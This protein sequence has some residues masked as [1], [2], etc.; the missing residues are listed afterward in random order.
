M[1]FRP[2][3]R[4]LR[5]IGFYTGRVLFGT[6]VC[7]A[8]PASVAALLGERNELYAFV[9]AA[10]LA[11]AVGRLAELALH[12]RGAPTASHG[13]AVVAL[14]WITVP[15]FA[16]LPLALSGHYGSY[17]DAY[18]DAV[19]GI[20]TVG[21]T[22]VVDVD[23]LARSVNLWRHLLQ[24]LGGQAMIVVGLSLLASGAGR[25]GSLHGAGEQRERLL[26]DVLRA[27]RFLGKVTAVYATVG[28]L[29]LWVALWLGGLGL[30]QAAYHAVALFLSAFDTGGFAVQST[31]VAFYRSWPVEAIVGVL[32][33][34]GA[35]NYAV[36]YAL[37]QGRRGEL[38]RNL[39]ART[40]FVSI[41][42]FYAIAVIGLGRTGTFTSVGQLFRGGFFNL[43]SAHTTTGLSTVPSV[44]VPADWGV[45]APA[46]LVTAMAV[47]GMTNSPAGGIKALRLG[48]ILKGL[49]RDIQRVLLPEN[50][51]IVSTYHVVTKRILRSSQV[52]DAAAL[53][54]L[55]LVLYL[56]GGM[57]GLFYGY[58]FD[59]S[60]FES[61]AAA[62]T[63]GLSTGLVRPALEWPMKAVLIGQMIVGRLE[64][65]SV[66]A[67]AGYAVAAVRGRV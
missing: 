12:T 63:G 35:F 40:L 30:A 64:F 52:R 67:L 54:L 60:L 59:V 44:M 23:H 19:S 61:T 39:E 58:G 32:M 22:L 46:M 6:G 17:L 62:S 66:F 18:F 29:G 38:L 8:I 48:L 9:L 34:A 11:I 53:L 14:A 28:V 56:A 36:H 65:V 5:I 45:L 55:F 27:A 33:V 41:I 16:A 15:L 51:V 13:L 4:D 25:I 24:F 2:D 42:G 7:M 1:L 47:G 37:W 50:A 3:R 10:A 20:S 57:L 43:L 21:L 49:Q 31:S 26:P